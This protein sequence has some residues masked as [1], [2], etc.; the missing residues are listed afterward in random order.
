MPLT[1][2]SGVALLIHP[3][4]LESTKSVILSSTPFADSGLSMDFEKTV[5]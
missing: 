2:V 5:D 1:I 3:D 4:I